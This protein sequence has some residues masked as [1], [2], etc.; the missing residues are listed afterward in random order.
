MISLSANR[1]KKKGGLK[2]DV[3]K[4]L[5]MKHQNMISLTVL[6]AVGGLKAMAVM[7]CFNEGRPQFLS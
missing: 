1:C 5:P 3:K 2:S 6:S 4:L 7:G